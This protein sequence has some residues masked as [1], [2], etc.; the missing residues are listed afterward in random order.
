[1]ENEFQ[2]A[3]CGAVY[4]VTIAK[5]ERSVRDAPVCAF[6]RQV[7][8]DSVG[9]LVRKYTLKTAPSRRSSDPYTG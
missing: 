3:Q 8:S 7:M 6:C 5:V 9:N 4:D 1:M 2:C